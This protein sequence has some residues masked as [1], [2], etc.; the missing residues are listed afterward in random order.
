MPKSKLAVLIKPLHSV[1]VL[2]LNSDMYNSQHLVGIK[3]G[4][5][6]ISII[7]SWFEEVFVH[8]GISWVIVSIVCV[9]NNRLT[10]YQQVNNMNQG[11]TETD[12]I[13][14]NLHNVLIKKKYIRLPR[15]D[16]MFCFM[17]PETIGDTDGRRRG[18]LRVK[19]QPHMHVC[20]YLGSGRKHS[21]TRR[22]CRLHSEQMYL[23]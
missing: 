20:M 6:T 17:V 9:L 10:T 16:T 8:S 5:L 3:M 22:T 23:V 15:N 19:N 21:N 2:E 13:W 7:S 11:G 18:Q 12:N 4:T 1:D 14:G